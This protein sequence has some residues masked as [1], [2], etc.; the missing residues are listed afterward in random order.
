MR[1]R[2]GAV[3]VG[4]FTATAVAVVAALVVLGGASP[5]NHPRNPF[6]VPHAP[7]GVVPS[8]TVTV[9]PTP[10]PTVTVTPSPSPTPS[11]TVT[12][13]P[14]PTATSTPSSTSSAPIP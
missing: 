2:G 6:V 14:S 11:P 10:S 4:L 7:S 13:T 1:E 8:P 12:I 3:A 9:T 5:T